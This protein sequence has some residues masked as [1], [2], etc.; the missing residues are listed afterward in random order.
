MS[1]H[2]KWST[3]KRKK[4]ATDAKRGKIFT[5]LVRE[6]TIAAKLGGGDPDGN[7]R[8]R[9][10]MDTAQKE[11]MPADNVKRAIQKGT[12]E[13]QGVVY[14]E[15]TYEGYGPSG[16]AI[17]IEGT[18]DNRNRTFS[19]I[20]KIF[21]TKGCNMGDPGSVAYLFEKKGTLMVDKEGGKNEDDLTEI[22][23]QVGADDLDDAGDQFEITCAPN[24]LD[25]IKKALEEKGVSVASEEIAQ[26][27]KTLIELD[28]KGAEKLNTI[29]EALEE[30]EDVKEVYSNADIS[31]DV[32]AQLT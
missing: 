27:A 12:G 24:S 13:I 21:T 19:E 11:N 10:A 25:K 5:K 20:R 30:H 15:V 7:P 26:I 16:V 2:S 4:G 29:V 9:S 6:I 3:I 28:L 14:E 18:T 8:L 17:L 1:G 23:L 22:V 31:A 32:L